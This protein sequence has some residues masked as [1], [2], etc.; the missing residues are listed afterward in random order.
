MKDLLNELD[1]LMQKH[2]ASDSN[3]LFTKEEVISL[4]EMVCDSVDSSGTEI[5]LDQLEASFAI[6]YENQLYLDDLNL[7]DVVHDITTKVYEGLEA[8]IAQYLHE[9]SSNTDLRSLLVE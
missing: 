8:A 9:R 7:D 4:I 2:K 6:N 1:I 5:E 3:I